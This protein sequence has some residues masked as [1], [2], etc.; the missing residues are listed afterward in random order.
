M[1]QPAPLPVHRSSACR[2]NPARRPELPTAIG[3]QTEPRRKAQEQEDVNHSNTPTA[4][5]CTPTQK[6]FPLCSEAFTPR[7]A[8]TG[9]QP[10]VGH[11]KNGPQGLKG[12]GGKW[13]K[14]GASRGTILEACDA[15]AAPTFVGKCAKG[16]SKESGEVRGLPPPQ[17]PCKEERG[18]VKISSTFPPQEDAPFYISGQPPPPHLPGS[19]PLCSA[20][21]PQPC[22]PLLWDA[23]PLNTL[24][25]VTKTQNLQCP[26]PLPPPKPTS[27]LTRQCKR[28]QARKAGGRQ[29]WGRDRQI[30]TPSLQP[31]KLTPYTEMP[32]KNKTLSSAKR[33]ERGEA[34]DQ[35]RPPLE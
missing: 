7:K 23:T 11:L 33:I 35:A 24:H 1:S 4:T 20:I 15:G 19:L 8:P 16:R 21:A 3:L 17:L 29:G 31:Q 2:L 32:Y 9:L 5:P 14:G 25:V 18:S 28:E 34:Q 27:V 22:P 13:E 12:G 10:G 30:T 6:P 26:L